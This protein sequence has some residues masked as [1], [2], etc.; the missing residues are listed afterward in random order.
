MYYCEEHDFRLRESGWNSQGRK[1]GQ[2]QCKKCFHI[3]YREIE[4]CEHKDGFY[5]GE[6]VVETP[7]DDIM[8]YHYPNLPITYKCRACGR[9]VTVF[10]PK[11]LSEIRD[12]LS[13][14]QIPTA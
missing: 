6:E 3:E 12:I 7:L 2:Y 14:R 8:N 10:E 4:P 5:V 1:I 9:E 13:T 11:S